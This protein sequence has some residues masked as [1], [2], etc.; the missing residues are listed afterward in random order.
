[1]SILLL[2]VQYEQA[3]GYTWGENVLCKYGTDSEIFWPIEYEFHPSS[4]ALVCILLPCSD[5]NC[6]LM[7][8]LLRSEQPGR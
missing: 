4:V 6:A 8:P 5:N 1:M 2:E 3:T 7:P